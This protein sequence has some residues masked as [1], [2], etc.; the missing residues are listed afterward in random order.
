MRGLAASTAER[1]PLA[2][3]LPTFAESGVPGFNVSSWYGLFVPTKTPREIVTKMHDSVA[4][5]LREPAVKERYETLG[6]E[7]ASTTPRRN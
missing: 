3:E 6:V 4:A 5:I 1:S 7:A 2:P